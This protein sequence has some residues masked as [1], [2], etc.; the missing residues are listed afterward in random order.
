M[1]PEVKEEDKE[2]KDIRQS[3]EKLLQWASYRTYQRSSSASSPDHGS[4]ASTPR[5]PGADDSL[6]GPPRTI[7]SNSLDDADDALSQTLS[8]D[9]LGDVVVGA[10]ASAHE[11]EKDADETNNGNDNG[12]GHGCGATYNKLVLEDDW[13]ELY[14]AL[15]K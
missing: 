4:V 10:H 11:D 5:S 13:N 1:P 3:A 14:P 15:G 6:L 7:E 2:A 8:H 9:S 12:K